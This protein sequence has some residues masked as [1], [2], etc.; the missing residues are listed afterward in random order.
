MKKAG[1]TLVELIVVVSFFLIF[2]V[3]SSDFIIRGLR[4]S[5][6]GYQQDA[7]VQNARKVINQI[8]AETRE[9][10]RSDRG[11]YLLDTAGEQQL[12]FYS[13]IDSDYLTEKIKYYLAGGILYK[14]ITKPAGDPIDYSLDN[15]TVSQVAE[16]INNQ[17][18][19][20][21]TYYD[22]NNNLI[23]DPV[24]DKNKIRLIHIFL[25]INVNPQ[26]AP[27]DYLVD[28][29]VQIRNLKDNL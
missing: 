2:M 21:F 27:Q 3:I 1:F 28:M 15:E 6:F 17:A 11:D 29:D 5:T 9:A 20:V 7:A 24:A 19:P 26:I 14:G 13:N 22:T 4:S 18:Q 23:A 16:Y 10:A 8:I 25:K 12:I